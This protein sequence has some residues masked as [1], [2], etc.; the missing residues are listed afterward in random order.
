MKGFAPCRRPLNSGCE[1]ATLRCII[2]AAEDGFGSHLGGLGD[3]LRMGWVPDWRSGLRPH[4]GGLVDHLSAIGGSRVCLLKSILAAGGS[5]GP[6][7]GSP[8]RC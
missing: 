1:D 6:H 2:V 8:W 4:I 3:I 7:V 5:L